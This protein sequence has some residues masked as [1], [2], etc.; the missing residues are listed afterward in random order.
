VRRKPNAVE[1]SQ[2]SQAAS[3]PPQGILP[4]HSYVSPESIPNLR[5][6]PKFPPINPTKKIFPPTVADFSKRTRFLH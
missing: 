5:A 2:H 1:G 3:P 4:V 6:P